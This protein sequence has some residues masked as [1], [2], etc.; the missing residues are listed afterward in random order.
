[1]ITALINSKDQ[2]LREQSDS[3]QHLEKKLEELNTYVQN[4]K[5]DPDDPMGQDKAEMA[6]QKVL[7]QIKAQD[8]QTES[9]GSD[10]DDP[11]MERLR[12]KNYN[13]EC[14]KY[15]D[16]EVKR[17]DNLKNLQTIVGRL[18]KKGRTTLGTQTDAVEGLPALFANTETQLNAT[19]R[20]KMSSASEDPAEVNT[21]DNPPAPEPEPIS[22]IENFVASY[23]KPT[24]LSPGG[25]EEQKLKELHMRLNMLIN[26]HRKK[27]DNE[28][29][30]IGDLGKFAWATPKL[31]LIY[32]QG[33]IELYTP[34][35]AVVEGAALEDGAEPEEQLK[36][37]LVPW[38]E[39]KN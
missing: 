33:S 24:V 11:E 34:S 19:I 27:K 8:E 29:K 21:A 25:I 30:D 17:T 1:M 9:I 10:S 39:F 36:L 28:G 7:A 35:H 13:N 32:L 20:S 4:S 5:I 3:I 37:K 12:V 6:R 31:I 22:Q 2:Q 16:I 18:L 15:Q 14:N 38:Y 23:I 26:R